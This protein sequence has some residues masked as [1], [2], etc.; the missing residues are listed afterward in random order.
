MM[1]IVTPHMLLLVSRLTMAAASVVC[2]PP[3]SGI[4]S[5]STVFVTMLMKLAQQPCHRPALIPCSSLIYK[6]CQCMHTTG[7]FCNYVCNIC[8]MIADVL[9]NRI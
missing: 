2:E 6:S 3:M 4:S 9:C 7:A 8:N 1:A 5:V